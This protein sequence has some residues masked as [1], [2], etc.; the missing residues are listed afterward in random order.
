MGPDHGRRTLHTIVWGVVIAL[1]MG[2]GVAVQRLWTLR[3]D[4]ESLAS[5]LTID[6][7][8][9]STLLYDAHDGVISA[10]FEEHRIGVPLAKISP[11]VVHAVVAI[12]DKRFW[13]HGGLDPR[14]IV[15]AAVNNWRQGQYAQGGSTIT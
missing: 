5:R 11:H 8:P 7:G 4:L 1:S 12:E 10:L 3:L 2:A 15:M 13:S 6:A 14:R 9:E